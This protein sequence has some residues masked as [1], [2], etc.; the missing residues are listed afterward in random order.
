MDLVSQGIDVTSKGLK[1]GGGRAYVTDLWPKAR[2]PGLGWGPFV[3]IP[4]C[5]RSHAVDGN[6]STDCFGR[7]QPK[8]H[9]ST[10]RSL[11]KPC[12]FANFNLYLFAVRNDNR[13]HSSGFEFCE[14]F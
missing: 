2:T 11:H 10:S 13:E 7:G 8:P 12:A 5:A 6:V 1:T 4:V 14:F 9:A 3:G